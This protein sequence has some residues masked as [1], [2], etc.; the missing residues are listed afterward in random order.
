MATSKL[1]RMDEWPRHQIGA[2]FDR[3]DNESPHWSDGWYFT[4][5]DDHGD[6]AFFMGFR[7]YANNDVLDAFACVSLGGRQHNMRWSRRLRPRIDD[8]DCGA[9]AVEIIEGLRTLRTTAA[10][11]PYG[12]EFD[13]T[14]EGWSPPYNEDHVL[15][16][17]NGR[18]VTDRSNYD[19]C[20]RVTGWLTVDGHR[21][22]VDGWTGVRDHSWGIGR[23]T[24]GPRSAA[25]APDPDPPE[26]RGHRQ[27]CVFRLPDRTVSW[28][29]HHSAAG[30]YT[31]L[32][33][34]C[35]YPYDDPREPF[36]YTS[37]DH[38]ATWRTV[39]GRPVRRL[40]EATV[41]LTRPDGEVERY[42]IEPISDPVYLQ[43][44]GYWT[45]WDD[46]RGRGVYRGDLV[47]EG[48]I[49]DVSHPVEVVEPKGWTLRP[50]HYAEAWGRCTNLDDPA[51]T[52]TGHLEAVVLG[53]YP[54]F[55]E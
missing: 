15:V 13:L 9:M 55:D 41:A 36:A 19:Q 45:G 48:E 16:V 8:L 12:I 23:N 4:T 31:M 43:G 7:L 24:G 29:F 51:D 18:V 26:P 52:G 42:R 2:T 39:D 30:E 54:G 1:T 28:Q 20:C 44:G 49:W 11:N 5:G 47:D 6:L 32:E 37:V 25:I 10:P 46:Q 3:L 21:Q 53:P 17:R 22:E 35:L 14:W 34:Q 40:A 27:W 38:E 50:D 33:T